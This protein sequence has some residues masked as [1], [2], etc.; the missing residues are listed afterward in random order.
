[1]AISGP[2]TGFSLLVAYQVAQQLPNATF[3]IV[4]ADAHGAGDDAAK[5]LVAVLD[6]FV[7]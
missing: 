5:R 3:D 7:Q 2:G 4:E 6:R 1:M